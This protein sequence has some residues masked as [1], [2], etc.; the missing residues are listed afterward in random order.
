MHAHSPVD[1]AQWK[2]PVHRWESLSAFL[3]TPSHDTGLHSIA[4]SDGTLDVSFY[5]R[6]LGED[7]PA[8]VPVIFSG[9]TKERNGALGPYFSGQG[10]STELG[11]ASISVADPTISDHGDLKLAWYAGCSRFHAERALHSLLAGIVER[12]DVDLLLIGGS[13]GGFAALSAVH[14]IGE[15]AR[16]LAWNPQTDLLA[17]EVTAVADY[18]RSAFPEARTGRLDPGDPQERET[19]RA[20][21]EGRDIRT[22]LG[23]ADDRSATLVLQNT[24]D[25]HLEQHAR[26]YA[27]RRE[28]AVEQGVLTDGAGVVA[29][30][31]WGG[32]H[33]APPREVTLLATRTL[34]AGATP[35][36]AYESVST[37]FPQ[38]FGASIAS[39]GDITG[40][41]F[42]LSS[43]ADGY[44]IDFVRPSAGL[45]FAFYVNSP[46][47]VLEKIWYTP[48][49]GIE[50]TGT[51]AQRATS[52]SCFVRNVI[53]EQARFEVPVTR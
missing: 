19:L 31:D 14:A 28:M 33:S 48:E 45:T 1:L 30:G 42:T 25:W 8:T 24:G 39:L 26:P 15:R 9:A 18:V 13:G 47:G 16:V 36:S 10:I 6:P 27:T 21:F 38:F 22:L 7:G 17:Y 53:V 40:E 20:Y 50:L 2:L 3:A 32:G 35:Q 29:I 46:D 23:G 34:L 5:G 41:D 44:R 49:P 11:T 43:T 52:V 4:F 12:Y 37:A 51:T